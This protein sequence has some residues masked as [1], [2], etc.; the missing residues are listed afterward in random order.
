M[1]EPPADLID[2]VYHGPIEEVLVKLPDDSIDCIFADPDYNVGVRYQGRNYQKKFDDYIDWCILWS[3]ECRRVLKP[4]GN[5]FIINY[6]KN[7]AHLR[8]RY[9]DSAFNTVNEY[10]WVYNTNIGHASRAFT[11]AHRTI[12]HCTKTAQNRFYKGPV[13]QP[14]KNPTDRRIRKLVTG[15]SPGRMPYS[16]IE[17]RQSDQ[18]EGLSWQNVNLVKNVSRSKSIHACQIPERLSETLF[19]ATT[20]KGDVVLVLFA[21]SG[22]ELAVCKRLGLQWISA[23]I[24]PQ[25]WPVIEDRLAHYGT[26]SQE[27][28]MLTQI[29]ERK[30]LQPHV[31]PLLAEDSV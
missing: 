27:H 14:Y 21:G 17:T 30:K 15:G 19:R 4:D 16:W 22:S 23:E 18:V 28:R 12:L 1:A 5:F 3:K 8:V 10:V 20:Q 6:G 7:N 11:T 9:L 24:V 13:A 31:K 2:R 26:V 25:Y 29:V